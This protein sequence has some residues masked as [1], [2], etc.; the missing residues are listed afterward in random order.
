V[1]GL[2]EGFQSPVAIAVLKGALQPF[3]G[4]VVNLVNAEHLAGTR[5][6]QVKRTAHS[7]PG[8]YP[9]LVRVK[10]TGGGHEVELGGTL[11]A[12]NDA[13]VVLFGGYRL[14]FRPEGR[15]LFLENRDVPGVVGK[16]GTVLGNAGVNIADIHLARR[17]GKERALAVLRVDQAVDE[18]LLARLRGLDDVVSAHA[19]D[20]GAAPSVG[21]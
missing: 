14:E 2:E 9:H 8:E 5:G 21:S 3:L 4:E 19:L 12:D 6:V 1:W 15:L 7:G 18:A 11:L 10:L 20:L 17:N 16:L 13:R